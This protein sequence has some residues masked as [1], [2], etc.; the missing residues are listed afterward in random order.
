MF[1]FDFKLWFGSKRFNHSK[2]FTSNSESGTTAAASA[3]TISSSSRGF[4]ATS[5][6]IPISTSETSASLGETIIITRSAAKLILSSRFKKQLK[7]A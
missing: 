1:P 3:A 5:S 6:F 4:E 2:T 7:S